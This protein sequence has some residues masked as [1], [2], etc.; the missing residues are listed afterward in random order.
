MTVSTDQRH[1][2][3]RPCPVCGG[4]AT[5]G[6]RQGLRCMGFTSE[7]GEWCR[8]SREEHAKGL[9]LEVAT[10]C[11]A[12]RLVGECKCGVRHDRS[13]P[14]AKVSNHGTGG[15]IV[16]T[17]H[18]VNLN[19]VEAYTVVRKYPKDFFQAHRCPTSDKWIWNLG[20]DPKEVPV[21]ENYQTALPPS[22]IA[23]VGP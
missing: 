3:E 13:P 4:N 1:N 14:P 8:C 5:Q 21:P 6:R 19:G 2:K 15:H 20:G 10:S 18:Y 12:H 23:G 7:D 17:Y 22:R 9:A 16:D 11:Y